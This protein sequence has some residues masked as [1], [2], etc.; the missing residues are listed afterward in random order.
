[1]YQRHLF[2][3]DADGTGSSTNNRGKCTSVVSLAAEPSRPALKVENAE[4]YHADCFTWLAQRTDASIHA[5][6]TDPPYGLIEYSASEQTKLRSGKGGVWRIP[7]SFD[8]HTRAPLPRFT[9]LGAGDRNELYNFFRRLAGQ[10]ARVVVPGGN[11]VI[12]SNTLL[13]HIVASAMV[14]GGLEF[15]GTIARLIMTMRGGDRPKN[16][17]DEFR[18]VSVMPRSMWEP[19]IVLRRPLEG[20]VQDNLRKW[21]TGGFPP[22]QRDKPFGDVIRSNPTSKMERAIAPHPSLKPQGFLRHLARGVLPVKRGCR[23]GSLRRL[24]VH[25]GGMQRCRQQKYRY[26]NRP[27]VCRDR[28]NRDRSFSCDCGG[29]PSRPEA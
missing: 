25:T 28:Q 8:G 17:H 21:K 5:V 14:D 4:L 16:A 15:R 24:R 6:V 20:R 27:G 10:F 1:M 26:R 9:V 11:I 7:P 23:F 3:Q 22:S 19:W 29:R 18:D 2:G 12:A 13:S